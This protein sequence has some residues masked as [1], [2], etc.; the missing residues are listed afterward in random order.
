MKEYKLTPYREGFSMGLFEFFESLLEGVCEDESDGYSFWHTKFQSLKNAKQVDSF[1]LDLFDWGEPCSID[2]VIEYLTKLKETT[3]GVI[4][5]DD[6]DG[7]LQAKVY[8]VKK[9]NGN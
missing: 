9:N 6:N 8:E 2:E 5:I 1:P 4:L 7:Y 3:K